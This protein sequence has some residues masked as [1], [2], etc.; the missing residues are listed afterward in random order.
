MKTT[1]HRILHKKNSM[2]LRFHVSAQQQRISSLNPGCSSD[3][4]SSL[5]TQTATF[6]V[7]TFMIKI[8]HRLKQFSSKQLQLRQILQRVI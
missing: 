1:V 8:M 7:A 5:S 3:L 2:L 6:Q 4:Y